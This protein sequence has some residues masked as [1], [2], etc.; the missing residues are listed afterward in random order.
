M[1]TKPALFLQARFNQPR[2][3]RAHEFRTQERQKPHGRANTEVRLELEQSSGD[4]TWQIP[5]RYRC[6]DRAGG[7]YTV[8]RSSIGRLTAASSGLATRVATTSVRRQKYLARLSV[9][10]CLSQQV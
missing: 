1:I 5:A 6:R 7:R 4:L 3:Q 9:L 8:G 2:R 10:P